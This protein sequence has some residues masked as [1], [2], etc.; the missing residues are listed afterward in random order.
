MNTVVLSSWEPG[1]QKVALTKLLQTSAGLSLSEAKSRV[2]R[3]LEGDHVE[4]LFEVASEA[5]RFGTQASELGAVVRV[6]IAR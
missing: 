5:E 2:D 4:V 3:L 1:L 6:E